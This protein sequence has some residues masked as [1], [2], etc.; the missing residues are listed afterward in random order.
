MTPKIVLVFAAATTMS[1]GAIAQAVVA[2]QVAP[3]CAY[4]RIG[5]RTA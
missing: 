4:R 3:T 1:L 5:S 2:V